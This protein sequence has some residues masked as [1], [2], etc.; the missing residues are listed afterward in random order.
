[1][2]KLY[3]LLYADDTV[4]LA[5]NDKDLQ[6]ALN[7]LYFYCQAEKLTVNTT[8]T[9]VIIFSRGK[10]KK[11]PVFKFGNKIIE[12]TDDYGY[13]GCIFNYNGKFKK[14]IDERVSQAKRAMF[15]LLSKKQSM[16]LPLD[17]TC[18]L[19]DSVVL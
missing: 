11:K 10:V 4:I 14:A 16:N 15:S 2:L 13:L 8:K 5:E 12:I 19:F 17:I 1:M 18:H 9:K 3:L 7:G 6:C